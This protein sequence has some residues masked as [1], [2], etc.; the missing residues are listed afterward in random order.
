MDP[1]EK[2]IIKTKKELEDS[3]ERLIKVING[4]EEETRERLKQ[5]GH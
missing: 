1:N 5:K 4:F 3:S 2:K